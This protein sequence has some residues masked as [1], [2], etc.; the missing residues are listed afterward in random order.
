MAQSATSARAEPNNDRTNSNKN[1][2]MTTTKRPQTCESL[3]NE[4]GEAF[5]KWWTTQF[6]QPDRDGA[7]PGWIKSDYIALKLIQNA[8]ES[9]TRAAPWGCLCSEVT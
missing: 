4:E 5:K 2:S 9:S 8:Y 7:G 6:A 3:R 1:Q